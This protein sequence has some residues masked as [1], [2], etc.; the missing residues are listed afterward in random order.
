MNPDSIERIHWILI[1]T[2]QLAFRGSLGG[3]LYTGS[4]SIHPKVTGS[5]IATASFASDSN[6]TV[7]GGDYTS[8]TE[9]VYLDQPAAGIKNIVSNKIQVVDMN[10]PSGST[11]SQ[12]LNSTTTP[13][14]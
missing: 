12:Y 6:F 7:T 3:E 1:L 4:V 8:N 5:W 2:A 14:W 9:T 13:R 10:L 11:L